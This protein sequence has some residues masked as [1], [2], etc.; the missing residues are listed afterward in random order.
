VLGAG[1]GPEEC[2]VATIYVRPLVN[3]PGFRKD[4]VYAVDDADP[5]VILGLAGGWLLPATAIADPADAPSSL[6]SFDA[7]AAWWA[8]LVLTLAPRSARD[9]GAKGDGVTDDT[10]ALQAALDALPE[11]GELLCPPGVYM[12]SAPLVLKRNRTLRGTHAP[13]WSY[14]TGS[15]SCIRAS[16]SFT[17]DALVRMKDEEELTGTVSTPTGGLLAGPSDQSGMRLQK[18]TLD[19]ANIAGGIDGVKAAGLVRDVDLDKVT[20]RRCTGTGIHTVGYTRLSAATYYPRGWHLSQVVADNCGNNGFGFNL[21]ND[22]TFVDCLAVAAT[23]HGFFIAGPGELQFAACRSVW[24]KSGHGWYVTGTSYGNVVFSACSTDRN[25]QHGM[26]IDATGQPIVLSGC[27][28]RRDGRNGNAGGGNYAGLAVLGATAPVVVDGLTTETGIEDDAT[29]PSSPQYGMR[30]ATSRSV[31]VDSGVLWGQTAAYTDGGGN[32]NL[33]I[34]GRVLLGTGVSTAPTWAYQPDSAPFP[35]PPDHGLI[36]WSFDPA[37]AVNTASTVLQSGV[38]TQVKI[39][40]TAPATPAS[41]LLSIATAGAGLTAGQSFV[42]LR[43]AAG[44]LL[45][46]S[47]DQSGQFATTGNKTIAITPASGQSLTLLPPG[48]YYVVVLAVGTTM[49]TLL[50][51]ASQA[52]VNIGLAAGG[53]RFATLGAGLTALPATPT[54]SG[55]AA[56][57]TALWVGVS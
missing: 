55:Q 28:F 36:A 19:G 17:G 8:A 57:S 3:Q 39:R 22:S 48:W 44:V 45:G 53:F 24:N 15:P 10:A 20:V 50:R 11:G 30:V 13:R 4:K 35:Q 51:S 46:V 56:S 6:V 18:L 2:G 33:R 40:L 31:V 14:D 21:L 25:Q 38:E 49:P 52:V 34:G 12:I 23:N 29:G 32:T 37:Q 41:V 43:N 1:A 42:G 5:Y 9:A 16:A 54:M 26:L 27:A 7:L 47:A